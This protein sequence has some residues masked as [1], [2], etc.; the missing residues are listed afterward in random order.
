MPPPPQYPQSPA[1]PPGYYPQPPAKSRKGLLISLVLIGVLVLGG[2]GFAAWWFLLRSE[3]DSS[4]SQSTT[5]QRL[6]VTEPTPTETGQPPEPEPTEAPPPVPAGAVIVPCP[7][8]PRI[9]VEDIG[10]DG[11]GYKF[12]LDFFPTCADGDVLNIEGAQLEIMSDGSVVALGAVFLDDPLVIPSTGAYAEVFFETLYTQPDHLFNLSAWLSG[13]N[14]QPPPDQEPANMAPSSYF[15]YAIEDLA[16]YSFRQNLALSALQ[17]QAA[18]DYA[19]VDLAMAGWWT[20]QIAS[21]YAGL[22]A[23]GLVW[24]PVMIWQEFVQLKTRYP[25]AVLIDSSDWSC[26]RNDQ[27]VWITN[28]NL[29]RSSPAGVFEWCNAEN[30]DRDNCLAKLIGYFGP[31]GTTE[32]NN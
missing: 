28:I 3:P 9:T 22:S 1:M 21:K 10:P 2:G 17:N 12:G 25:D 16:D 23:N 5:V 30:L 7:T 24:T 27:Q 32:Y 11:S 20:P 15:L 6:T 19:I 14:Q 4:A 13:T 8:A 18:Y 26:Y 29:A 31:E